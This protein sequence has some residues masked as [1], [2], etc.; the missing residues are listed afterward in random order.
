MFLHAAK[1]QFR[2]PQTDKTTVI[3]APL[4]P[5]L[6]KFLDSLEPREPASG[7]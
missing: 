6:T 2:H 3:E 7:R 1:V 5:A 4:P